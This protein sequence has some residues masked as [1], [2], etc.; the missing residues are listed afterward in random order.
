MDPLASGL[1]IVGI[2]RS[3]TKRFS[4]FLHADKAY[5]VSAILGR[6]TDTYDTEGKVVSEVDAS[7]ISEK[8][9]AKV[10]SIFLGEQEQIPPMYSALKKDGKKLYE[11]AREGKEIKRE[12]RKINISSITLT[13][14]SNPDFEFLV[15][16][17][18]GTY[19]R[20]ICS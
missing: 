18:G 12:P 16:V 13:S 4:E 19:I 14:F 8:D 2:G 20:T 3:F 6:K 10:L 5:E 15:H 7:N 9:V 1:L 11:L 17:S